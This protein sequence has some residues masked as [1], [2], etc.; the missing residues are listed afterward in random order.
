MQRGH[1]AARRTP[2]FVGPCRVEDFP[3]LCLRS[4]GRGTRVRAA[5][6]GACVSC[7]PASGA[8]AR[9]Q[10]TI[11]PLGPEKRRHSLAIWQTSV[12]AWQPPHGKFDVATRQL[13]PAFD[14]THIGL[15]GIAGEVVACLGAWLV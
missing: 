14:R 5:T 12:G 1:E 10:A 6:Q 3:L 11:S 15:L 8:L 4:R 9:H 7:K 13:T 2:R